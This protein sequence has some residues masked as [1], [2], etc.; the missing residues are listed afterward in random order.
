MSKFKLYNQNQ[1]LLLP[2]DLR[3]C[4][5]NDHISFMISDLVNNLDLSAIA[6]TYS[7][8]GSP[9]Y[10]PQMLVKVLFYGYV[11]GIRSSRKIEAKLYED[12]AFRFLAANCQ[13]D[14]GTINLFRKI[15]LTK[16]ESIFVQLVILCHGLDIA[17]LSN[18]SVDGTKI[19]ASASRKNLY[20]K[21]D[22]AK[23]KRKIR[24]TLEESE[25]I[26]A[27]EDKKYGSQRGYNAMPEKFIDPEARKREIDKLKQKL[28]KIEAAEKRIEEKQR[29]AKTT[30]EKNW[31]RNKTSNTTDAEANLLK[32]KDGSFK[33]AY[34]AQLSA[35]NQIIIAYDVHSNPTDTNSFPA[36]ITKT[37]ATTKRKVKEVKADTGYFSKNNLQ[38][39][40]QH[41]I[42]AYIP[43]EMKSTEERQE[44]NGAIPKYDRRNFQYDS[45]K[46]EFICPKG[47]RLILRNTAKSG[48]KR[49][50]GAECQ[51]CQAKEQCTKSQ[52]RNI[53]FDHELEK[54][55]NGMRVK[56]NSDH[57]KKKYLERMSDVEPVFG[58]I[59]TSLG[60]RRFLVRGK[61]MVLTEL[62]LVCAAHN[63]VKIFHWL[64]K[65]NK[66]GQ[67]IQWNNLMR[68]QAAG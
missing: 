34:N 40:N 14:H 1:P 43:D 30:K 59:K 6:S 42:D 46:D 21:E 23:L 2:R 41:K 5:P 35:A 37:E 49:Y 29:L 24:Q 67:K 47:K 13:P 8:L 31:T 60:F 68:L 38:F 10:D 18:I 62:G 52:C 61:R 51:S 50:L 15:H 65:N 57:G 32:T 28:L 48:S 45:I 3:D 39:S 53:S 33:M 11:Q 19:E 27:A 36:M 16:L 17:D 22:I 64:K 25:R 4:L 12:N 26:D 56:L 9:A 20:A 58:H 7:P 63:L 44:R 54:L 66:N 55:K